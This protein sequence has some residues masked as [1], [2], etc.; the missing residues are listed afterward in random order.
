MFSKNLRYYRLK[1]SMTKRELAEQLNITPM[2]I[3]NY[4]SGKRKPDMEILKRMANV[5]GVRVSDFL[6]VRNE[7]FIFPSW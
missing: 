1:K 3:S 2:A 6:A 4:E 7:N 5:L